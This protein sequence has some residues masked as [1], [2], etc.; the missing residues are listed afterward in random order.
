MAG[1][2]VMRK[3]SR[4]LLIAALLAAFAVPAGAQSLGEA[5]KREAERRSKL[6]EPVKVITNEDIEG[7]SF[8]RGVSVR[9]DD[10]KPA[11]ATA[12]LSDGPAKP[13]DAAPTADGTAQADNPLVREKRDE[14]H[15]RERAKVIRDRL[16]RLQ[17]DSTALE[18]RITALQT[19]L[20]S[21]SGSRATVL[22]N[23]IEEATKSLTRYQYELGLINEEWDKFE[24]RARQAKIPVTWIR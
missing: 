7:A 16:D 24:E 20:Q 5:A 22:T 2:T 6:K 10:L 4:F 8:L 19:E 12:V 23:E 13:A 3:H 17:S 21:A 9:V 15:W 14:Q 18:G 11:A 1:N